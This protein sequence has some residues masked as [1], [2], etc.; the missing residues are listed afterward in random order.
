ME[1][2]DRFRFR[3]VKERYKRMNAFYIAASVCMW[4]T[5]LM[6]LLMKLGTKSIAPP[7]VYGNLL[8]IIA[9]TV[10]DIIIYS[11]NRASMILKKQ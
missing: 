3:D 5:F 4:A 2:D 6:Y 10:A 8:F 9:F 1:K 7:T 11:R